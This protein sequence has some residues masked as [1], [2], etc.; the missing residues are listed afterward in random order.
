ME[1]ARDFVHVVCVRVG[2]KYGPEYVEILADMVHRNLSTLDHALWCV[3]DA[4]DA[5]PPGVNPI[6]HDPAL[7][8]WWQ[9]VRLFAGDMPWEPGSRVLYLDLDVA[10]VGRLEDFAE[11]KGIARDAGWPCFNSSVMC[12]DHGEHRAVWDRFKPDVMTRSPGPLVPAKALPAGVPNGGDQEWIT[13]VGGWETLPAEWVVSYKRQAQSWPPQGARVVIF[14]G[15]PK[16]HEISEGWVPNV[17]KVGGYTSLPVMRG[18][19][20]STDALLDNVRANVARGLPWFTGYR[21]RDRAEDTAV[22]VCG[23]PSMKSRVEEIR[24]RKRRGERLITVNNALRFLGEHGITPDAHVMLDARPENAEF[25]KGAPE[26]V[27]YFLASQCH[28]AVFEALEDRDVVVWHNFFGDG[29]ELRAILEPYWDAKP[30]VGVPGGGTVG[31]RALNLL[32]LSGYRR[33]HIY[34]MDGSYAGGDHHAY[35][36]AL[37]DGERVI[38]VSHGGRRF[39]CALWMIRQS[40]EFRDAYAS[41][42]AEG[43]R[44]FLHGEGLIPDIWRKIRNDQVFRRTS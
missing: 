33:V 38:E 12:W 17:W 11:R 15:E 41:L 9:K 21:R 19:N 26:G 7:P 13:E 20:V 2:D 23:G 39:R 8:G 44:I 35:P 32:W 24:Q 37:N 25:V 30:I 28:P 6:P 14:H 31:L 40:E 34:G 29:T 22:L 27:T 5:L 36:Q 10:V 4:P 43:L 16:N 18:A 42:R 1:A 3:T